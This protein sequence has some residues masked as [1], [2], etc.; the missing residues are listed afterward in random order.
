MK[1]Y[2]SLL[3]AILFISSAVFAQTVTLTTSPVAASNIAQGTTNNIVYA[4]R[5]DVATLPVTVNSIQF[6]L[7]GTHDN[8]D[9]TVCHV[10]FNATAPTLSGAFFLF[11]NIPATFAAPHTYNATFAG[12]TI[13][14][15]GSGYFI[16][17]VNTSSSATSGN[18]VKINGLTDPVSFNYTTSPT[19]TNNQTDA[20][21][22]QTILAAGVTLTTS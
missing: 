10:Y 2:V 1:K 15:G 3:T 20:A 19:I 13:A 14:A 17:V 12:Q 9:L 21:G 16:I 7:G 22:V 4:A 6:N 8:N 5:M 11:A 18:T